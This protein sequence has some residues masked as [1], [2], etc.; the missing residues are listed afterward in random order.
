MF[1]MKRGNINI[2]EE[3][4]EKIKLLPFFKNEHLYINRYKQIGYI[5]ET[6]NRH[7]QYGTGEALANGIDWEWT[8]VF[9]P[10]GWKDVG[11]QFDRAYTGYCIPPHRD[12]FEIYKKKFLHR[13]EEIKRRLVFLED[14]K[15]GHYF[16]VNQEVFVKWQQ[17]DWIEFGHNDTHF[18]GNIGP[19]VRYTLQITGVE[20]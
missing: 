11:L 13:T 16:Q 14:W 2:P 5:K 6:L 15:S 12:H 10:E 9:L 4:L 3:V 18:G 1:E 7:D 17:G 8:D 20:K 19:D